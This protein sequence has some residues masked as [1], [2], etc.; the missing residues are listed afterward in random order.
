MTWMPAVVVSDHSRR[1]VTD[2]CLA[3]EFGLLK[4]GHADYV[5]APAPVEIGFCFR[6]ELWPLHTN[7]CAT[8][9][10]DNVALLARG[11]DCGSN[12]RTGWISKSDV[13]NNTVSE[14][15][16]DATVGTVNKLVGNNEIRG[17][18]LFLQG[19]HGRDRD[20]SLYTQSFQGI[21]VG[22]K[23][24]FAGKDLMS[25]PVPGEERNLPSF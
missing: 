24:Q 16:R 4:I 8:H 13:R 12:F 19:A 25:T 20:N 3:G 15:S 14:E 22:A 11:P 5:R 2:F 23:I 10:S 6:G 1:A 17:L 21:N 9:L 7:V 18:V